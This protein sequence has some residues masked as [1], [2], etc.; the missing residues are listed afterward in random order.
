MWE[1]QL[2]TSKVPRKIERMVT[3]SEVVEDFD[4]FLIENR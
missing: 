1:E 4:K 2:D 3:I